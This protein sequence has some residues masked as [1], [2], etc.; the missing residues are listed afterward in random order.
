MI[1]FRIARPYVVIVPFLLILLIIYQT[2]VASA[3]ISFCNC[4]CKAL[5]R[6]SSRYCEVSLPVNDN[7]NK[8]LIAKILRSANIDTS[9]LSSRA[10]T[11]RYGKYYCTIFN[12]KTM[13]KDKSTLMQLWVVWRNAR[14]PVIVKYFNV[15][16]KVI[17][18]CYSKKT[19]R[20]THNRTP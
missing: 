11:I 16:Y 14:E 19:H 8:T 7:I 18:E 20:K 9:V 4:T 15:T 1:I 10:V 3:D 17:L 12:Y 2:T 13:N 5:C 6:E